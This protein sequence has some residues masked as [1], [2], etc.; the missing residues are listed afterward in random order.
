MGIGWNSEDP[1]I[2]KLARME[3][4]EVIHRLRP[5]TFRT[6]AAEAGAAASEIVSVLADEQ[7][8]EVLR[9]G[10]PMHI[11]VEVDA[12][13]SYHGTV[14]GPVG[15]QPSTR[16][17]PFPRN[18]RDVSFSILGEGD[19]PLA[20]AAVYIYGMGFPAQAISDSSGQAIVRALDFEP[21]GVRAL[22]VR[23][24]ADY[25]ERYIQ[26]PSV[27]FGKINVIRLHPLNANP[28][29]Y[30][31]E[32]PY[33]WGQRMMKFDRVSAEWTGAGVKIGIIDSGCDEAHPI[34]RHVE[35]GAD[36]TRA[37]DANSWTTDEIGHGTHCAGIIG[38]YADAPAAMVGCAPG[39]ELHVFKV[40]PGGRLSDLIDALDQCIERRLDLVLLGIG[41]EQSSELVAQKIAEATAYG[42]ACI[43]AAGDSGAAVQFPGS[44]PGVLAVAAVGKLGEFPPD[45]WHA[46]RALPQPIGFSGVFA[47]NFSDSGPQIAVCAP[48]V[49]I[50]SSV[51]GGG[52]AAW[53]GS[54]MAASFVAGFAAL[55]LAHHPVL[56]R[57]N[58]EARSEQRVAALFELIRASAIP[59]AQVDP[60]RVGA[61]LPDLQQI[62][63]MLT[64]GQSRVGGIMLGGGLAGLPSGPLPAAYLANDAALMQ[65]RA[66]GVWI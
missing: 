2:E 22:Y 64:S 49:A 9:Q 16:T 38:G 60:F 19:R 33:S 36:L 50:I 58:Y 59:Y 62:P 56:Q 39:A 61:G 48:G 46:H 29:K 54:S 65:L 25:W 14:P 30:A 66:A 52:Y 57:G 17:M 20:G 53:D 8:G 1:F 55:L 13:L 31:G 32:R 3:G 34:L 6:P 10:A 12:P 45:S 7:L 44:V 37:N 41:S 21:S 47:T 43:A 23:P 51:P 28:A 18:H 26:Y 15:W 4:V 63:G 24:A 11:V 5:R 40:V 42:I 27:E 35:H